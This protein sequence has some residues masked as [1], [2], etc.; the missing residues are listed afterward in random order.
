MFKSFLPVQIE[1]LLKL[2]TC[3]AL[4]SDGRWFDFGEFVWYRGRKVIVVDVYCPDGF[5]VMLCVRDGDEVL[6]VKSVLVKK[7]VRVQY[8]LC[9]KQGRVT[10]AD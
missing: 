10:Q 9:S 4:Y 5:N 2:P 7:I 8:G 1:Q 3:V 6:N